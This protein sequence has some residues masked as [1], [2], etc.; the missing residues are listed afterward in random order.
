MSSI[1][2]PC[3]LNYLTTQLRDLAE[4]ILL[5]HAGLMDAEDEVI[6]SERAGVPLD[7]VPDPTGCN[8]V[9]GKTRND[10][11]FDASHRCGIFALDFGLSW[12]G[13]GAKWKQ[14]TTLEERAQRSRRY[15]LH[16]LGATA[17]VQASLMVVGA[18]PGVVVG[19]PWL[20]AAMPNRRAALRRLGDADQTV[21]I[22]RTAGWSRSD[23]SM[24]QMR[25]P[26]CS[27][28]PAVRKLGYLPRL[29]A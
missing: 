3:P 29:S 18:G 26:S 24:F 25:V 23:S 10:E 1:P 19:S 12:G 2:T 11:E 16:L 22:P 15:V 13:M 20:V 21:S 9:S 27:S 5:G 17:T 4:R 28:R 6:H 7:V 8:D 14:S